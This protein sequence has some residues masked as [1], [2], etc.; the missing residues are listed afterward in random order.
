MFGFVLSFPGLGIGIIVA[1]FQDFGTL[2]VSHNSLNVFKRT[3][4]DEYGRCFKNWLWIS[5]GAGDELWAF[6]RLS[7]SLVMSLMVSRFVLSFS[8]RVV[9]GQIWD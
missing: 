9:L 1:S 3:E 8:P 7:L 2:P 6:E 5:S 4:R